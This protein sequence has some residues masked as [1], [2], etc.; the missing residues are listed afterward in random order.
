MSERQERQIAA[1]I[2]LGQRCCRMYRAFEGDLR[3]ITEDRNGKEYRYRV[4]V[5]SDGN[6]TIQLF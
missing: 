6:A 2:P 1:Q 5:D 4:S 3:L